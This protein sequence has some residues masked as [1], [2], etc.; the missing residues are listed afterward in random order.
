M[1]RIGAVAFATLVGLWTAA[2]HFGWVN[3]QEWIEPLVW[4]VSIIIVGVEGAGTL[5]ARAI[6]SKKSKRDA[7]MEFALN[8]MLMQFARTKSVRYEELGASV[9]VPDRFKRYRSLRGLE[10]G[11][12]RVKRYRPSETPQQTG[13]KWSDGKGA[14]G[15][16]WK[17]RAPLYID[18][19]ALSKRYPDGLTPEL[20]S[21]Q[22][23]SVGLGMSREEYNLMLKKYGEVHAEPIWQVGK[24]L[25]LIGVLTIDRAFQPGDATFE[26]QF[27]S[28]KVEESAASAAAQI[29]RTLKP[30][31]SND[32]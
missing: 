4:M 1:L 16:C 13:I 14:V 30:V 25:K 15:T 8:T 12:R 2:A 32:D 28:I 18:Q 31:P 11:F 10:S 6:R 23:E 9:Y 26:P 24:E 3:A 22:P 7:D 21:S 20:F 17:T 19:V 29:S 27:H 5:I